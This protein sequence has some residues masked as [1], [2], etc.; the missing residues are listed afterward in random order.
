MKKARWQWFFIKLSIIGVRKGRNII[1]T[2]F[3]SLGLK[4]R[5]I[6]MLLN[7]IK[8]PGWCISVN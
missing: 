3:V 7:G 1:E 2:F 6:K 5:M 8:T 4:V